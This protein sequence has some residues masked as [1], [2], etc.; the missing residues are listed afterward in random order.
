LFGTQVGD[1][2]DKHWYKIKNNPLFIPI[3]S[4]FR[5][6]KGNNIFSR[7]FSNFMSFFHKLFN[8]FI[9]FFIKPFVYFFKVV[10]KTLFKLK[11]TLGN[12]RKMA[13]VTRNLFQK[14][15]EKTASRINNSY[16]AITYFQEKLKVIIKKQSAMFSLFKQFTTS[17]NMVLYSFVKGPV[18]R[19]VNFMTYYGILMMTFLAMCILCVV[20]GPFVKMVA[21]PVCAICF[22]Q[23]TLIQTVKGTIPIKNITIGDILADNSKVQGVLKV[24]TGNNKMYN[25]NDIIV[26][27]SHLVKEGRIWIRVKDSLRAKH[28]KYHKDNILYCLNTTSNKIPIGKT[29]FA[30]YKE[31]DNNIVQGYI[32]K[33]ILNSLN[34]QDS[35]HIMPLN[36]ANISG[37]S[38]N[39]IIQ[40]FNG[41][42]YIS[43]I[44]I[45]DMFLG[46]EVCVGVI[47][48]HARNINLYKYCNIVIS[49]S[50]IV[51]KD[52]TWLRVREIENLEKLTNEKYIYHIIT[53]KGVFS[54]KN[55]LFRDFCETNDIGVNNKIDT[56]VENYLNLG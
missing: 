25:Y 22:D 46:G 27:G 20:G 12:F 55:I 38:K 56:L 39:T 54:I 52:N 5:K 26:S 29:I 21:C 19:I 31:T 45:G 49:G 47:K 35:T 17:L 48:S 24:R 36:G 2:I 30:D 16:A 41:P 15:V 37:F 13:Q 43:N 9:G 44:K 10:N 32:D 1:Y 40:T 34:R 7:T 28:I 14:T 23:D 53:D 3:A 50:N 8:T 18:P 33:Y 11:N 42:V 4:I 6:G 51:Y